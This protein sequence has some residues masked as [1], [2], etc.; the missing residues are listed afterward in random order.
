[1]IRAAASEPDRFQRL[2]LLDPVVFEPADYHERPVW[3]GDEHPVARRRDV[4]DSPEQMYEAFH[5]RQP[6][7]RW[8]P[9]VLMDYCRYGLVRTGDAFR[10]SCPPAVEEAVYVSSLD[11]DIHERV[12]DVTV[13]VTVVRANYRGAIEAARDFSLSPTWPGLAQQ[14]ASGTDVY[15]P[16][17]SHFMPMENPELAA[18]L[19]AGES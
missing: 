8:Q 19:I 9:D 12:P 10:L 18:R 6:Y 7:S 15:L 1:M 11:Y 17:E 4:W 16:D 5:A 13:D 3:A 2:V 14:F